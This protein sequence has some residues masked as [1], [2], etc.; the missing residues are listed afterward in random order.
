MCA[1]DINV[2]KVNSYLEMQSIVDSVR[3]KLN[4]EV[5][6]KDKKAL[7]ILNKQI[8]FNE[9]DTFQIFYPSERAIAL[10]LI[11]DFKSLLDNIIEGF[12]YHYNFS[13]KHFK[14][15]NK[16]YLRFYFYNNIQ[17]VTLQELQKESKNIIDSIKSTNLSNDEKEFLFIYLKSILSYVDLSKFNTDSMLIDIEKY[18]NKY[19]Y[20]KYYDYTCNN[21]YIKYEKINFGIGIGFFSGY[22]IVSGKTSNYFNNYIPIGS[23]LEG[24][25]FN[26][27]I[28]CIV[29][30][31]IINH[32][33]KSISYNN[34]IWPKGTKTFL[35]N[36]SLNIGYSLY[37]TEKIKLCPY[38][39][40]GITGINLSN[41]KKRKA[42]LYDPNFN[43]G[44]DYDWIFSTYNSYGNYYETFKTSKEENNFYLR[45]RLAYSYLNKKDKIYNGS[46]FRA[47]IELGAF[48]VFAKRIYCH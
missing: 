14:K 23:T 1:Q 12:D 42:I 36:G 19:P 10:F 44:I 37:K 16:K 47:Q 9:K 22:S 21:L 33:K 40:L 32:S 46:L 28:K 39:G 24:E 38:I 8:V 20:S 18:L 25:Y 13:T 29:S 30:P 11:H 6:R 7:L 2:I 3:A 5:G 31:S 43:I 48:S 4:Y 17:S 15:I 27:L 41:D 35:A 45:F 34:A 26:F